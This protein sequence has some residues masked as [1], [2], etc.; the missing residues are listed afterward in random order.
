MKHD[1]K[2]KWIAALRSGE[3]KQTT[4]KLIRI[5]NEKPCFCG[6]GVLCDM[7]LKEINTTWDDDVY[8]NDC[9][10]NPFLFWTYTFLPEVVSKWAGLEIKDQAKLAILNDR[11][12]YTFE[13]L[14]DHIENLKT[15]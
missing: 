3:Y 15:I 11:E 1:I 13:Q 4:G 14:A 5:V 6:I 12:R 2:Q 10:E 8:G 9:P 7:Y